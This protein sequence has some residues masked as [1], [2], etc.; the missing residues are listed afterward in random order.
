MHRMHSISRIVLAVCLSCLGCTAKEIVPQQPVTKQVWP[1]AERPIVL[2]QLDRG[3]GLIFGGPDG[4]N[5]R[6]LVNDVA[7]ARYA[8]SANARL[9]ACVSFDRRTK[10]R[11]V[12]F[13]DCSGEILGNVMLP[14]PPRKTVVF[15]MGTSLEILL[16]DRGEAIVTI[17]RIPISKGI[18]EIPQARTVERYYVL[19]DGTVKRIEADKDERIRYLFPTS[20]GIVMLRTSGEPYPARP[21][22]IERYNEG[23]RLRWKK[24][25]N[26][27]SLG[28]LDPKYDFSLS[29]S[30]EGREFL[31]F[32]QD[33][34]FEVEQPP[35]D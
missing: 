32:R 11:W 2:N 16:S 14:L 27:Y 21:W 1:T 31:H 29:K 9:A 4:G 35:H 7:Y 34:T 18:A 12:T 25:V 19:S 3:G 6:R 30:A 5:I 23:L 24:E 20:G 33:G 10:A 8:I 13:F 22:Q 15:R 28:Y 26:A 17:E